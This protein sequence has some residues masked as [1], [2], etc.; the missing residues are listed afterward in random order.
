[1]YILTDYSQGIM[2]I[3]TEHP[4]PCRCTEDVSK[5]VT[6]D[7]YMTI[8]WREMQ[9]SP[10]SLVPKPLWASRDTTLSESVKSYTPFLITSLLV[11][12]LNMLS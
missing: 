4:P 2:I 9:S 3:N 6:K 12:N 1:M 7:I 10:H 11:D 5:H 8:D